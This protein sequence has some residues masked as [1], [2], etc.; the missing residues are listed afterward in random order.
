[1]D[2]HETDEFFW[3]VEMPSWNVD[4]P[5][6]WQCKECQA[7]YYVHYATLLHREECGWMVLN[8]D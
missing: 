7:I 5:G 1:M 2:K 6:F 4:I 8:K 3:Y